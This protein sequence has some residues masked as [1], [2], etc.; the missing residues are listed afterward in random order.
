MRG[1]RR[2]EGVGKEGSR[3]QGA[4]GLVGHG[5]GGRFD[6]G[7]SSV[8]ERPDLV[9]SLTVVCLE[10]DLAAVGPDVLHSRISRQGAKLGMVGWC[11]ILV[12]GV[13]AA[14]LVGS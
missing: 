2:D 4:A 6:E 8:T 9:D 7:V 3:R 12:N 11:K 13:S 1:Q 14:D 5:G 10:A